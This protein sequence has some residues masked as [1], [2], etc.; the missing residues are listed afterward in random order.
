MDGLE[1]RRLIEQRLIAAGKDASPQTIDLVAQQLRDTAD[2]DFINRWL[3]DPAEPVPDWVPPEQPAGRGSAIADIAQEAGIA[4][5]RAMHGLASAADWLTGGRIGG[6]L[7]PGLGAAVRTAE[8]ESRSPA[9]KRGIAAI[10]GAEGVGGVLGEV[11][12]HPYAAA[13]MAAE[14]LGP[15]AAGGMIAAPVRALQAIPAVSRAAPWLARMAPSIGEG[16]VAGALEEGD[17]ATKAM[18]AAST[19]IIGRMG[20]GVARRLGLSDIDAIVSGKVSVEELKNIVAVGY[21]VLGSGVV[22]GILEEA[23]QEAAQQAI[24]NLRS[25]KPWNEGVEEAATLGGVIGFGLGSAGAML[26]VRRQRGVLPPEAEDEAATKLLTEGGADATPSA[27]TEPGP[28]APT[29]GVPAAEPG[30][31]A[32]GVAGSDG[33]GVRP[34]GTP[35]GDAAG[36]SVPQRNRRGPEAGAGDG[37]AEVEPDPDADPGT[38]GPWKPVTSGKEKRAVGN[39]REYPGGQA[40]AQLPGSEG[41]AVHRTFPTARQ[42]RAWLRRQKP[43]TPAPGAAPAPPAAAPAPST[44][45]PQAEE[46]P[47]AATP[48]VRE[49]VSGVFEAT[50]PEDSFGARMAK[51]QG[52]PVPSARF[53]NREDAATWLQEEADRDAALEA[54][55][56]PPAS[57]EWNRDHH[58][59]LTRPESAAPDETTRVAQVAEA[60]GTTISDREGAGDIPAAPTGE[61][62]KTGAERRWVHFPDVDLEQGGTR[63]RQRV[64]ID[65]RQPDYADIFRDEETGGQWMTFDEA[66]LG[67]AAG[68]SWDTLDEAK[69]AVRAAVGD[70]APENPEPVDFSSEFQQRDGYGAVRIFRNGEPLEQ[71]I[72]ED[73]DGAWV[74]DAP[75][76]GTEDAE[77]SEL[78]LQPGKTQRFADLDDAKA[79]VRRQLEAAAGVATFTPSPA[80]SSEGTKPEEPAAPAA[81]AP[82]EKP[83]ET[84]VGRPRSEP[85]RALRT[86]IVQAFRRAK[87]RKTRTDDWV[88]LRDLRDE[89]GD[90]FPRR[91]VDFELI[92]LHRGQDAHFGLHED[93]GALTQKDRDSA[94]LM[95]NVNMHMVMMDPATVHLGAPAATPDDGSRVQVRLGGSGHRTLVGGRAALDAALAANPDI[96]AD[97]RLQSG[98]R[99]SIP[100]LKKLRKAAPE[101]FDEK[102]DNLPDSY[103]TDLRTPEESFRNP[104]RLS[105]TQQAHSDLLAAAAERLKPPR[106][107][108]GVRVGDMEIKYASSGAGWIHVA[109][110]DPDS[111]LRKYGIGFHSPSGELDYDNTFAYGDHNQFPVKNSSDRVPHDLIV[112]AGEVVGGAL[113]DV[114]GA[115]GAAPAPG[116]PA[117]TRAIAAEPEGE[118]PYKFSSTQVPIE[119]DQIPELAE[120]QSRIKES[121]QLA[122][123]GL[124]TEPHV[125]VLY[126]LHTTDLDEVHDV[127]GND[128]PPVDIQLGAV[129]TFPDRGDGEVVY[130]EIKSPDLRAL[131]ARYREKLEYT[132]D[133]PDYK[134]HLTVAYVKPGEGRSWTGQHPGL[135]GKRLRIRTLTFSSKTGEKVDIA[136]M[137]RVA[138]AEWEEKH[139][140]PVA[141]SPISDYQPRFEKLPDENNLQAFEYDGEPFFIGGPYAWRGKPP[142][143]LRDVK[144]SPKAD[145]LAKH[146]ASYDTVPKREVNP[147]AWSRSAEDHERIHFDVEGVS[148]AGKFYD[149]A[150]QQFENP[151]FR[152]NHLSTYEAEPLFVYDGE[153]LVG[154]I[155][156]IREAG[157]AEEHQG[158]LARMR[159][160]LPGPRGKPRAV[161]ALGKGGAEVGRIVEWTDGQWEAIR[162]DGRTVRFP[163]AKEARA[164]LRAPLAGEEGD[165]GDRL[166]ATLAGATT[167]EQAAF[168]EN[169]RA[170]LRDRGVTTAPKKPE[171]TGFDATKA[172]RRALVARM[173]EEMRA[174]AMGEEAPSTP[175]PRKKKPK[176]NG[177]AGTLADGAAAAEV[178]NPRPARRRKPRTKAEAGEKLT[179]AAEHTKKAVA[180]AKKIADIFKPDPGQLNIGVGFTDEQYQAAKPHFQEMWSE[181]KLAGA[182]LADFVQWSVDQ[183]TGFGMELDT[184]FDLTERFMD[185]QVEEDADAETQEP[186]GGARPA[187][188]SSGGPADG[189]GTG[190]DRPVGSDAG[191]PATGGEAPPAEPREAGEAGGRREPQPGADDAGTRDTVEPGGISSGP[192]A[193]APR[194]V[195]GHLTA[196]APPPYVLTPA[197]MAAIAEGGAVSTAEANVDA[198]E[199]LA[200]LR[201]EDRWPTVAEQEALAKWKGWGAADVNQYLDDKPRPKWSDRGRAIHARIRALTT[202]NERLSLRESSVNAHYTYGIYP[203]LWAALERYGV[204]PGL[205]ILSPSIGTGHEFMTMPPTIREGST[206]TAYELEPATAQIAKA[207]SPDA[208]VHAEGFEQTT[209]PAH[210][211]DLMVTNVP[212][213]SYMVADPKLPHLVRRKIHNYFFAKASTLLKPGGMVAFISTHYTMDSGEAAA[214]RE[215]LTGRMDFLGAVRLPNTAFQAGARTDVVTDII[216][217]RR[218]AEGEDPSPLN[219]QFVR[220]VDLKLKR[221]KGEGDR[222]HRRSEYYEK[223]PT[224]I[225]GKEAASGTMYGGDEYNVEGKLDID[226]F[227]AALERILPPGQWQAPGRGIPVDKVT[228]RQTEQP[229]GTYVLDGGVLKQVDRDGQLLPHKAKRG[230]KLFDRIRGHLRVKDALEGVMKAQAAEPAELK[231]AQQAL[232]RAYDE[233]VAQHGF[234]NDYANRAAFGRDPAGARLRSL[235][236]VE[237]VPVKGEK[238]PGVRVRG[239]ADV[240]TKVVKRDVPVPSEIPHPRDAMLASLSMFGNLNWQWMSEVSGKG[241]PA[242]QAALTE[243]EDVFRQPDGAFQTADEYLRHGDVVGKLEQARDLAE[244]DDR[245]KRNVTALEKVQPQPLTIEQVSLSLGQPWISPQLYADFINAQ[246]GMETNI[247]P[248]HADTGTHSFWTIPKVKWGIE[249]TKSDNHPLAIKWQGGTV[250]FLDMLRMKLNLKSP[251]LRYTVE[252]DGS[253]RSVKDE[254]GTLA[255]TQALSELDFYWETWLQQD[256][257]RLTALLDTYNQKFNRYVHDDFDDS[258]I[259]AMLERAGFRLEIVKDGKTVMGQLYGHQ[260]RGI[261]RGV[262]GG[263][264]LIAHD[265]GAGKTMELLATAMLWK[266]I[267]RAN[268]PMLVVHNK[269]VPGFQKEAARIFPGANGLFLTAEDLGTKASREQAFAAAAYGEWDFIVVT[270]SGFDHIKPSREQQHAIYA[271]FAADTVAAL[272]RA[273]K[274]EVKDLKN[275]LAKLQEKI[276]ALN[277]EEAAGIA[278]DEMGVDG[279]LIDEAHEFKN[280]YFATKLAGRGS[281]VKGISPTEAAKSFRLYAKVTAIN[282]ASN[283]KNLVFATA[284]PVMN[285]PAEFYTMLRYLAPGMLRELSLTDFDSYYSQFLGAIEIDDPRPDGTTKRIKA[286]NQYKNL[287]T[288]HQLFSQVTDYVPQSDMPYLKLPKVKGGGVRTITTPKHPMWEEVVQP[289]IDLRMQRFRDNPTYK[290]R[291]GVQH[292]AFKIDPFTGE[293]LEAREIVANIIDDSAN[294]ALDLRMVRGF[295]HVEDF[296]ESRVNQAADIIAEFHKRTTEATATTPD[297]GA[298]FVF[299]DSGVP[300][301]SDLEPL[302]F[303]EGYDAGDGSDTTTDEEEE[304][305]AQAV[306][307]ANASSFNLYDALR[308]ALVERG[309]PRNEIAYVQQARGDIQRAIL[310]EKVRLGEVRVLIGSTSGGG[311]G[312][313][314]QDRLGMLLHMDVPKLRRPGDLHQREGRIVRQGNLFGEVELIRF[315]TPATADE[316]NYST[317]IRKAQFI[318]ALMR[319]DID[320]FEDIVLTDLE[321]A[322]RLATGDMRIIELRDMKQTRARLIAMRHNEANKARSQAIEV[323]HRK[324]ALEAAQRRLEKMQGFLDNTFEKQEGENLTLEVSR[325][326]AFRPMKTLRGSKAANEYLR[327]LIAQAAEDPYTIARYELKMGGLD[328]AMGLNPKRARDETFLDGLVAD[329]FLKDPYVRSFSTR[330]EVPTRLA[331]NLASYYNDLPKRIASQERTVSEI[332]EQIAALEGALGEDSNTREKLANL[333]RDI[334]KLEDALG[335]AEAEARKKMQEEAAHRAGAASGQAS[336]AG[337]DLTGLPAATVEGAPSFAGYEPEHI[338]DPSLTSGAIERPDVPAEAPVIDGNLVMPASMP[339]LNELIE[340]MGGNLRARK[341]RG[342]QRGVM[343][344]FLAP[345]R[346]LIHPDLFQLPK[347]RQQARAIVAHEIGHFIS[348]RPERT[349]AKG[350]VLG[351]IAGLPKFLK[352]TF[353]TEDGTE[354]ELADIKAELREWSERWKPLSENPTEAELEYRHRPGELFADAIS[355][356]LMNPR[357]L[358]R[359]A[360]TFYRMLFAMLP[361]RQPDVYEAFTE[362]RDRLAGPRAARVQHIRAAVMYG[363]KAGVQKRIDAAREQGEFIKLLQRARWNPVETFKSAVVLPFFNAWVDYATSVRAAAAKNRTP[364]EKNPYNDIWELPWL[365]SRPFLREYFYPV[366]RRLE[367]VG[368]HPDNELHELLTYK[369]IHSGDRSEF[370]NVAGITAEEAGELYDAVLAGVTPDQRA[371]LDEAMDLVYDGFAEAREEAYKA[372]LYGPELMDMM[373]SNEFYVPFQVADFAHN[374]MSWKVW[375]QKGSTR[376]LMPTFGSAML[377]AESMLRAARTNRMRR[378]AMDWHQT[379]FGTAKEWKHTYEMVDGR[380]RLVPHREFRGRK[381]PRHLRA[382]RYYDAGKIRDFLVEQEFADAFMQN[383]VPDWE[384]M[385]WQGWKQLGV[386]HRALTLTLSPGFIAK[387]A[388]RDLWNIVAMHPRYRLWKM[389]NLIKNAVKAFP[390]GIY[391]GLDI[392]PENPPPRWMRAVG[393]GKP[394]GWLK[395][396]TATSAELVNEAERQGLLPPMMFVDW[397]FGKRLTGPDRQLLERAQRDPHFRKAFTSKRSKMRRIGA[398][399]VKPFTTTVKI[400]EAWPRNIILQGWIDEYGSMD[401]IPPDIR[402][403]LRAESGMP[404]YDRAGTYQNLQGGLFAF[405]RGSIQGLYGDAMGMKDEFFRTP[406]SFSLNMLLLMTPLLMN[407]AWRHGYITDALKRLGLDE[408]DEELQ[409]VEA[410][411]AV[412][413]GESTYTRRGYVS[414]PISGVDE[415]GDGWTLSLPRGYG[416]IGIVGTLDALLEQYH[417]R[418]D[419]D[420]ARVL[421]AVAEAWVDSLPGLHAGIQHIYNVGGLALQEDFSPRDWWRNQD[422]LTPE[423]REYLTLSGKMG[424]YVSWAL[425]N[426]GLGPWVRFYRGRTPKPPDPANPTMTERILSWP[427]AGPAVGSY[428]KQ[429]RYGWREIGDDARASEEAASAR[430]RAVAREEL[431]KVLQ[432]YEDTPAARRG[433]RR[434]DLAREFGDRLAERDVPQDAPREKWQGQRRAY[435]RMAAFAMLAHQYGPVSSLLYGSNEE[436]AAVARAWVEAGMK[437]SRI[438]QFAEAAADV[439]AISENRM[440]AIVEASGG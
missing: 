204:P 201:R 208:T 310:Y 386:V 384:N 182:D 32:G 127:I 355:G 307:A 236:D 102:A 301:D 418:R 43:A 6:E 190:A 290:D 171:K 366:V 411:R 191:G 372:G 270:H 3:S 197:R 159:P 169:V 80:P 183:L 79:W 421:Q 178:A 433:A 38:P 222:V 125:T 237:L 378:K 399:I 216:V 371:A 118:H 28:G 145:A 375:D 47:P 299:A 205:H 96:K 109:V 113:S 362:L 314:V 31:P 54:G 81:P 62:P 121:G 402:H 359:T 233:F 11:A 428:I 356:L 111:N 154:V 19:A 394:L 403:R 221:K 380:F 293:E 227:N 117:A 282:D 52:L 285:S 368:L 273:D 302:P 373:R 304:A 24:V 175:R 342:H 303:L 422:V 330:E 424:R 404:L 320:K 324:E 328:L 133:F 153:K 179:S 65:G 106:R 166:V 74:I 16:L 212:F 40:D 88:E 410:G 361:V 370:L 5:L 438:K 327:D 220:T 193:D 128:Y 163:N 72:E 407:H 189:R 46:K 252:V 71:F 116:L 349:F 420:V 435:E 137:G 425:A 226:A 351:H 105:K 97:T 199:T 44:A 326:Y 336:F 53:T 35:G 385:A 152:Q 333:E 196:P 388:A 87:A 344:R 405:A 50:V 291:Q 292:G 4:P 91:D 139:V 115:G 108:P 63:E 331:T 325:P 219:E 272:D 415:N 195:G 15:M 350:N 311:T 298:V 21:K 134:P 95:G 93:Q 439:R 416:T 238:R 51:N 67:A 287:K 256:S 437:P 268:K 377:K 45:S 136:L 286:V 124:E 141:P 17:G 200:R 147:I 229:P 56:E 174:K 26:E 263:N 156:P 140:E 23:P 369:R 60:T 30:A 157:L 391:H 123:E 77:P 48:P 400:L 408:D 186:A 170:K 7:A 338:P 297:K 347:W 42:A 100:E 12:Q 217:M 112:K 253:R 335:T 382:V 20:A 94:L 321:D 316:L 313:N 206:L 37:A 376:P 9:M 341:P 288:L 432:D 339:E 78:G 401:A 27:G 39:I 406:A 348:W 389:P 1:V 68:G 243:S 329:E 120:L 55:R 383:T 306:A 130:I 294:A 8:E 426:H 423:E 305:E 69:D 393:L 177:T 281:R 90:A 160:K 295:E 151:V 194:G 66:P 381:L 164:W 132:S 155:A 395:E 73:D 18:V 126:G 29:P 64:M 363:T 250:G 103:W 176:A 211:Q 119:I 210:S 279:L 224:L 228:D 25:G 22:E 239:L 430:R 390:A 192:V 417:T 352:H 284:T 99:I 110:G 245:F 289:W 162:P 436:A 234:L 244:K 265:V 89:I 412:L 323:G 319:G 138:D 251:E 181:L 353:I 248:T 334:E 337:Y 70:V 41:E 49:I 172:E 257:S 86:A 167:E 187:P 266:R 198:M 396:K 10:G 317:V 188:R 104:L 34:P 261:Y 180:A 232:R 76:A 215:W 143:Y 280:L 340:A 241:A 357:A 202:A 434:L 259:V 209:L 414:V 254:Q 367:E 129:K 149:Y 58:D 184:A 135:F 249:K 144:K 427:L 2:P 262:V 142:D 83:P 223:N 429:T 397:V 146:M 168:E 33:G 318:E 296:K 360:P 431:E 247:L 440:D 374:G 82:T 107:G 274:E 419:P 14:S 203:P 84:A 231:E 98:V 36:V 413:Q 75:P 242:L 392:D 214:T 173:R 158:A 309:I 365:S 131:N 398:A 308:D 269:T 240:F 346:I 114:A 332:E 358:E 278:F 230:G 275:Q 235:E 277:R 322:R 271:R 59:V 150:I 218:R 343:G 255:L 264:L 122:E 57:T 61:R 161:K 345:G 92:Q 364:P 258:P 387:M 13:L 213:G 315:V 185:E 300:K 409:M 165:L 207:L 312:V 85:N 379:S 246:L 283:E 267:G 148:I 276:E 225:L 101:L 260:K 354:F